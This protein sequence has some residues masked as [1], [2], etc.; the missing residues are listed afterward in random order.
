[1]VATKISQVV[2]FAIYYIFDVIALVEKPS[3]ALP[4]FN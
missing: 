1:L 4:I 3:E 2:G